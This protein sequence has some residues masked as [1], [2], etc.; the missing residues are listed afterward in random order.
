M[1][2]LKQTLTECKLKFC[3][4]LCEAKLILGSV[5]RAQLKKE[6]EINAF[7]HL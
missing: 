2:L 6:K 5:K 7:Y 4:D 3:E 1:A